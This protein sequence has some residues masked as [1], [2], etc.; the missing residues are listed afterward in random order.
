M[1]ACERREVDARLVEAGADG[2]ETGGAAGVVEDPV[3]AVVEDHDRDARARGSRASRARPAVYIGRAVADDRDDGTVGRRERRA[4]RH[5]HAGAERAAAR[6]EP[7]AWAH[8]DLRLERPGIAETDSSTTIAS[9]GSTAASCSSAATASKPASRPSD[10]VVTDTRRRT[11]PAGALQF[12][13]ELAH[14]RALVGQD[15]ERR[16]GSWRAPTDRS[17][18]ARA[19]VPSREQPVAPWGRRGAGT[20]FPTASTASWPESSRAA[21]A[22]SKSGI[23][24]ACSTTASVPAA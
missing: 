13:G 15:R 22:V 5:R 8:R 20:A 2:L 11:R 17:R 18:R 1:C 6:A 19:S 7:R 24:S 4:D 9:S 16:D 14:R 12:G 3:A 21:A 23:G 10:R